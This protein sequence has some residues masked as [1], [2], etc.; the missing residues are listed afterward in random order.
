MTVGTDSEVR[1]D[2]EGSAW[3][4]SDQPLSQLLASRCDGPDD[5]PSPHH[6]LH[7]GQQRYRV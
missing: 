5:V 3:G 6:Y 7:V 4:C 2:R 1:E